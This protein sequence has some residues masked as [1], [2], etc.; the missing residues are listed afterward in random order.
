MTDNYRHLTTEYTDHVAVVT[1]NHPERR[2]S[3]DY[4][5]LTELE[6]CALSFRDDTETRVV[7]LTGAGKHFSS[8]ADLNYLRSVHQKPM[9]EKR[10]QIRLGERVFHA[11]LDIEQITI[12]AWNGAAI[13][14]G[15][16]LATAADLRIGADNCF[17]QYPEIDLGMNLMWQCLPRTTRLVGEPRAI[18][19]AICGEK[20]DAQSL[21]AWGMLDNVV[22][23]DD[24]LHEAKAMAQQYAAKPPVAAQ[25]IKRAINATGSKLDRAMMHA[26]SDQHLLTTFMDDAERAMAAYLEKKPGVFIGN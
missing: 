23:A 7:I 20:V 1:L 6:Q 15:A 2:N 5:L 11:I 19:L 25:M 16:C 3:L 8:G 9:I 13:G 21:L 22:P 24:L 26:D 17:V 14:G 12:C 18:R 10:R 4:D